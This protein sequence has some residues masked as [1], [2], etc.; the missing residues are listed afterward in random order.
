MNDKRNRA[1][2]NQRHG[3]LTGCLRQLRQGTLQANIGE[4]ARL[5]NDKAGNGH[6]GRDLPREGVNGAN[7]LAS[8]F[9]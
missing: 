2:A 7:C 5:M 4:F 1:Q 6:T 8:A 9:V 3:E